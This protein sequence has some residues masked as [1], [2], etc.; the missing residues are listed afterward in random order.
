MK[1]FKQLWYYGLSIVG[2]PVVIVIMAAFFVIASNL[3]KSVNKAVEE[4]EVQ[5]KVDTVIVEKRVIVKDTVYI[6][7]KSNPTP[8]APVKD[9]L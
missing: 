6:P 8:V 1:K 3:N 5:P 7:T 9:T 4:E 2:I